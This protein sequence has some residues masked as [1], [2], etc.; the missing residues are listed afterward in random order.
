MIQ[1]RP[2]LILGLG[3]SG[4]F[5]ARRLKKRMI[6]LVE[7]EIPPSI[8]ILAFDTDGQRPVAMLDELSNAEF[9]RISDFQGDNYVTQSALAQNPEIAAFWRYRSLAPGLVRDGAR[10]RPPVGRLAFFVHFD[11]IKKQ[12]SD[13]IQKIFQ[14]TPDYAPPP[15]VNA[16]DVYVIGSSCGGTGAGM[17]FDTALLARQLVVDSTREAILQAHVFLPSCFEGNQADTLSLQ[18][19][20][21]AFLKT[22]EALQCGPVP[23]IRYPSRTVSGVPRALFSRVHILAGVNTAGIRSEVLQSVFENVALQLDLEISSASARDM[24]SAIDNC[25]ADFNLRPQGRL[26]TYSSYGTALLTGSPDFC[27]LAVLPVFVGAILQSLSAPVDPS[28]SSVSTI[29]EEAFTRATGI[30]GDDGAALELVP[31]YETEVNRLVNAEDPV[32]AAQLLVARLDSLVAGLSFPWLPMLDDIPV[33]IRS[34]AR[35]AIESG[36]SGVPKAIAY[37]EQVKQALE[38]TVSLM[39][40]AESAQLEAADIIISKVDKFFFTKNKKK[41]VLIREGLPYLRAQ[42]L[43]RI[44]RSVV[45]KVKPFIAGCATDNDSQL[46]SLRRFGTW[47]RALVDSAEAHSR[48]EINKKRNVLGPQ[49]VA[50]DLGEVRATFTKA[51]HELVQ[52]FFTSSAGTKVI[53]KVALAILD[54]A[55]PDAWG[56]NLLQV[57]DDFLKAGLSTNVVLPTEWGQKAAEEI[58][59]CQPMVQFVPMHMDT[60]PR[61]RRIAMARVYGREA[62][63]RA[64]ADA[65][66]DLQVEPEE[67]SEPGSLEVTSM[68][69]NFCLAQLQEVRLVEEGY[70]RFA[71]VQ[72]E[73]TENRYAW[74]GPQDTW[75]RVQDTELFPLSPQK[76]AFARVLAFNP[77]QSGTAVAAQRLNTYELDNQPFEVDPEASWYFKYRTLNERLVSSGRA[78]EILRDWNSVEPRVAR[79]HLKNVVNELEGRIAQSEGRSPDSDDWDA[80]VSM[81]REELS[82]VRDALQRLPV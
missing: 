4:T 47:S 21:Y 68:V 17:F 54:G 12:I 38:R 25:P 74:R 15:N 77:P 60:G 55:G 67:S 10:Q 36:P 45:N 2:T 82:A 62:V 9:H 18:T 28:T 70:R 20:A 19:N 50:A 16:V 3:G 42:T 43:V 49:A 75:R 64:L 53:G 39:S 40:A 11:R 41:D 66:P 56:T 26:A 8:Q 81:L 73:P 57:A 63:K 23:S 46:V 52:R 44:R 51:S 78:E 79:E 34:E 1:F 33:A 80:Y 24:R 35:R 29:T 27:R 5:V 59:R 22:M 72:P 76:Q 65:A 37:L 69:L 14:R 32:R 71:S 31:E 30:L 61:P 58:I 7:G 48:D 6:R 13:A